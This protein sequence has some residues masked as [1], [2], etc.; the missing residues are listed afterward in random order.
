MTPRKK[1]EIDIGVALSTLID[2]GFDAIEDA[3]ALVKHIER[4]PFEHLGFEE[5]L[6]KAANLLSIAGAYALLGRTIL[7]KC[8]LTEQKATIERELRQRLERK[9]RD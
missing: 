2:H 1:M 7:T 6:H 3:T 9:P 5:P 4:M 8:Q